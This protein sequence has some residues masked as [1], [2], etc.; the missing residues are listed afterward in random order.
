M[1]YAA[2]TLAGLKTGSL[3]NSRGFSEAF[4]DEAEAELAPL[5]AAHDLHLARFYHPERCPLIYLY[6]RTALSADLANPE[7]RAFLSGYGYEPTVERAIDRLAERICETHFPHE[8]GCFLSYP[9]EDVKAF[10][11]FGGRACKLCG[12][13]CVF[14]NEGKALAEFA[15]YDAA[16]AHYRRCLEAGWTLA[17]LLDVERMKQHV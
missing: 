15:R 5:L 10:V 2:P 1:Q 8:I 3:F 16:T 12:H 4:L 9:I 14:Q 7:V 17:A 13:W 11:T 6:R